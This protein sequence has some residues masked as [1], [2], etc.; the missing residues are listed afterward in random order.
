VFLM[1]RTADEI[2]GIFETVAI[3]AAE[4]C[5]QAYKEVCLKHSVQPVGEVRVLR[6]EDLQTHATRKFGLDFVEEIK[7]QVQEMPN[8]DDREKSIRIADS[9]MIECQELAPAIV[10][11]YAP[12]YYPAVNS[13][14]D[15][16]V[17]R[18]VQFVRDIGQRRFNLP[19]K[20]IHYF[21]GISDLSYV[22]Y[23]DEGEGW[24][25]FKAN[26]P[27][28]GSS[29]CIPFDAMSQLCAPVLNVGP[30]GKDAHK[31]TE[32]LHIK[33]SFEEV[34]YLVENMIKMIAKS[35]CQSVH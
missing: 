6:Y 24:T 25:A 10:L 8:W 31:R 22:N 17:K 20:Q 12:P 15:D 28:W 32:R 18:C 35:M 11:L 4:A 7:S 33:N 14:E 13:S 2:M 23:H 3:D 34:P 29:Y 26:T 19:V 16:L 27:V 1:K 9:L 21:N 5:N 30:F